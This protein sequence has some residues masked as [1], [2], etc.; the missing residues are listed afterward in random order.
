MPFI[1]RA[2]TLVSAVLFVC[3]GALAVSAQFWVAYINISSSTRWVSV[4]SNPKEIY[5]ATDSRNTPPPNVVR[6]GT[7]RLKPD[8]TFGTNPYRFL[9][10]GFRPFARNTGGSISIPYWF[11]LLVLALLPATY[12]WRR[13]RYL[14]KF[15]GVLSCAVCGYDLRATPAR[16]PECGTPVAAPTG[17]DRQP[18]P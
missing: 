5:I 3:T 8:T 15:E 12:P 11:V 14:A 17:G 2:A 10:F 16:C 4:A 6:F 9:G 1:T 7:E 18:A 13:R